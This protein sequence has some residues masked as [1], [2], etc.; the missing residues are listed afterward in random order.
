M[1]LAVMTRAT[2]GHSGQALTAGLGTQTLYL[3]LIASVLARVAAGWMPAQSEWL[4]ML[5]GNHKSVSPGHAKH[6]SVR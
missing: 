4:H 3:L 6:A 5:A 1:T 2:L